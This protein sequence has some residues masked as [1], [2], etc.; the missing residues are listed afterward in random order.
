[1][2]TPVAVITGAASGIGLELARRLA[3]THRVALLDI[4]GAAA[5]RAAA[6]IGDAAAAVPCDIV[7][8][9]SVA[10]A[11]AAVIERFGRIDVAV[12]NAGIGTVGAARHLDPDVLAVQLDVNLTGNWRFLHACL[13]HL[14]VSRGYVLGVASA[15][16]IMSP[17]GE[18]F[19]GASKAGL[20]ALL[21]TLRTE[22]AHL[23]IDVGIAYLMF[24]DTPMVRDGDR[25]HADL[26]RMRRKLPGAAARTYPVAMAADLLARGVNGR[27]RRVFVPRSLRIQHVLR[28]VL[29]SLIDRPFRRIAVEVDALTE[30]KVRERGAF[31]AGFSRGA[32][33]AQQRRADGAATE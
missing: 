18:A 21:N 25:E 2:S 27:A 20:E 29:W 17:P 19:Y 31:A 10:A 3:R 9:D 24:I 15:A 11:V 22:V 23:G 26:A 12:S 5:E 4:D 13:P 30:A 7:R 32:L 1:M 28:G 16:A 33:V 8:S 6:E 14:A